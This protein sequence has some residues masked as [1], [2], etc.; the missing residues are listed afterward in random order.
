MPLI[1]TRCSSSPPTKA[2]WISLDVSPDGKRSSSTFSATCTRFRCGRKGHTHHERYGWDQQPR[3]SPD[4]SQIVFVSDRNGAKNLW[5]AN[6]DGTKPRIITKSDRI[7]YASPI[8]SADGDYVIATRAGQLWMYHKDGGSGRA[9]DRSSPGRRA[10]A[11]PVRPVAPHSTS[12]PRRATIR[13]TLWVNVSGNVPSTHAG[14]T[15]LIRHES[16]MT[17]GSDDATAQQSATARPISD[18]AV[19]SRD[20]RTLLRIA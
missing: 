7:N 19:R 20:R 13:G 14:A 3:Y 6:A 2:S 17:S 5:I 15:I 1:T 9:D 8:W 10:R 16:P 11:A 12:A 18:R 4:G